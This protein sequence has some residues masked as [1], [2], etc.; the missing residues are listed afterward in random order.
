MRNQILHIFRK[1]VRQHW[2]EIVLS[3]AIIVA[4]AWHEVTRSPTSGYA[5]YDFSFLS[6]TLPL[7]VVVAWAFLIVRVVQEESLVGDRQFWVTR[8][9]EWKR[10][11]V[12]KLL[13][14]LIFVNIPFFILQIFLLVNAGFPPTLYIAGLLLLQ[15]LWVSI[16]IW[17]SVTLATVTASIG[18][19]VL[20]VL[21]V[22][23]YLFALGT[24]SPL[25][26]AAGVT[27]ANTISG[28]FQCAVL[29]G[30]SVAVVLL[31]YARR[32][33]AHSRILLLAA[34]AIFPAVIF[35]SP[36]RMFI[37]RAYPRANTT[38]Q[39]P[40]Q[41]AFDPAKPTSHERGYAEKN[42]VHVRIP[43]LV[44]G[45]ADGSVVY[46]Q[47]TMETIQAPDG[48]LKWNSGWHGAYMALLPNRQHAQVDIKI[49]KGFFEQVKS[50]PAKVYITFALAS[51]HARE[52]T[53]I[54]AQAGQFTVPGGGRCSFSPLDPGNVLCLFPPSSDL[55]LVSARS[56]DVTCPPRPN[57]TPLPTGSIGYEWING[58]SF[59]INPIVFGAL[60]LSDWGQ[61]KSRD[62]RPRVCPGTPLTIFTD[63]E[64]LQRVRIDL[65][66]D[67][68]Q[69]ADYQLNDT[70]GGEE[71]SSI[72]VH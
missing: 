51:V 3:F 17:P 55:L 9:Y 61:A 7:L 70:P 59:G 54:V 42:K 18:Q 60:S 45:I 38:Q 37:E 58:A 26:P 19:F 22:V 49:E 36:F 28:P 23:L 13:F 53:R 50:I 10:L 35:A 47:G 33:T 67:G 24:L 1:D 69:L 8:P 43:L 20:G 34:A 6:Q 52:T 29:V 5:A 63:W 39:L 32:R 46:V 15:L 25:V 72:S 14:V 66:I 21:G 62:F 56:D 41:L 4:Y 11:L 30:A 40:V 48:G 71:A 57:E 16:L 2:R 68:I 65:E 44:S 27:G 31:Q 64:D 12:A